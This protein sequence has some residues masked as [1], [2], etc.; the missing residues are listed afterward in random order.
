[1]T[2]LTAVPILYA[3]PVVFAADYYTIRDGDGEQSVAGDR[4][5]AGLTKTFTSQHPSTDAGQDV[6]ANGDYLIYTFCLAV[7]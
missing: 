5:I 6:P 2:I 3:P 7:G 4:S 1:M